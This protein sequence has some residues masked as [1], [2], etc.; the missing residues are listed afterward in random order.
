MIYQAENRASEAEKTVNLLQREVDKLECKSN[1][2]CWIKSWNF[3][4]IFDLI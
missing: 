2:I 1:Q 4:D 3:P